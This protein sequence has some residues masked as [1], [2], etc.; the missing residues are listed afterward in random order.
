MKEGKKSFFSL[1]FDHAGFFDPAGSG[2]RVS[3][4][5][6]TLARPWPAG[7]YGLSHEGPGR[8]RESTGQ[9]VVV[10]NKPGGGGTVGPATMAATAMDGYTV[11]QIPI[12]VFRHPHM[13]KVT[14]DPLKDFTYIVHQT[15]YTFG[16]VVKKDAPED[17]E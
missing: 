17:M 4:R 13:M 14:W 2:R 10:D 15:G 12:T 9:T 6:V 1:C 7:F 8:N 16:V 11:S 3:T 5:P